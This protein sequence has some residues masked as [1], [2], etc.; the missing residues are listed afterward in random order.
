MLLHI[1]CSNSDNTCNKILIRADIVMDSYRATWKRTSIFGLYNSWKTMGPL[2]FIHF[3]H[4][5]IT[6]NNIP[7]QAG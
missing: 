3:K 5:K 6:I 1:V 7:Y 4:D 2:L